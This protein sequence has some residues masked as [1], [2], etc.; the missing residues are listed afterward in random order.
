MLTFEVE[1]WQSPWWLTNCY[2]VCTS[3][4]SP[5]DLA[6]LCKSLNVPVPLTTLQVPWPTI[7]VFAANVEIGRAS[8][9]ERGYALVGVGVLSGVMRTL[10]FE[11]GQLPWWIVPLTA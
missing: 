10:Q 1:S 4:V 3:V 5:A 7:A 11:S 8:C 9:R 2:R 6:G